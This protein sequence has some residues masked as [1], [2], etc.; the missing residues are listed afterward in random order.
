[1]KLELPKIGMRAVKTTVAVMV[2]FF[3][4]LPFWVYTPVGENDPLAQIGP[5]YACIAAIICMQSSVEQTVRQGVSRVIGTCIG[6]LVGLGVLLLDDLIANAVA[7][8]F[9]MGGG[10]LLTLWLCNL[11]KRP[12]ACSIGCIVVC[13]VMLN[14]S[15]PDRYLYTLFRVAETLVGI[16]VAVGVNRLLPDRRRPEPETPGG[17]LQNGSDGVK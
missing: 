5:F 8:G 11:I 17:P 16:L 3:L 13:V 1:M 2:C 9:I 14:H 10:V 12:A 6:G 7:T 4:F 15:G